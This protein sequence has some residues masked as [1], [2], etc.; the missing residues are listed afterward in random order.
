MKRVSTIILT[1]AWNLIMGFYECAYVQIAGLL[2]CWIS[3]FI[4]IISLSSKLFL[5]GLFGNLILT[6]F[7]CSYSARDDNQ[8]HPLHYGKM[9]AVRI[10]A[11]ALLSL[12]IIRGYSRPCL[13]I[14]FAFFND[15]YYEKLQ[16]KP[17]NVAPP[18]SMPR[19]YANE[20]VLGKGG[21]PLNGRCS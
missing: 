5:K 2:F 6:S 16:K 9:A 4:I 19:M 10:C 7:N 3:N 12:R 15:E 14:V 17:C 13:K 1:E 20:Q 21:M 8:N 18:P 11:Q